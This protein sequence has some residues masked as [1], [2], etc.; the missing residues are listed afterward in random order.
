MDEREDIVLDDITDADL[1]DNRLR[2]RDFECLCDRL[3]FDRVA[4]LTRAVQHLTFI[5]GTRITRKIIGR[6]GLAMLLATG[7]YLPF[8]RY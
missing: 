2:I 6:S 8:R 1:V 5:L 4:S 3:D 7:K